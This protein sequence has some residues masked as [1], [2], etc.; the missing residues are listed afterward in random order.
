MDALTATERDFRKH[1]RPPPDGQSNFFSQAEVYLASIAT[2]TNE[3]EARSRA[4]EFGGL[5]KRWRAFLIER[6]TQAVLQATNADCSRQW[7]RE[8]QRRVF[9]RSIA[10]KSLSQFGHTDRSGGGR[11]D[12]SEI[13]IE[14]EARAAAI[15]ERFAPALRDAT[16]RPI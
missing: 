1:L 14:V 8:W 15:Y 13:P 6:L 12:E 7:A 16:H 10:S 9:G 2:S 3:M 4:A 5:V 11:R